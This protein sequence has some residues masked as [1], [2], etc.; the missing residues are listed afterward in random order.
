QELLNTST[1]YV[2]LEPCS[3]HG[4]TPPCVD[5]IIQKKIPHVVIGSVD[6][7][8]LVSGKGIE[9][10][11]SAGIKVEYGVLEKECR[12]LNKRFYTFH[13]KK[14]PYIIL[15]WAQTKDGFIDKLRSANEVGQQLRISSEASARL[16]HEWRSQEQA[17]MVGTNTALL[18]NP[19]L[20]VR[21]V[22]GK[23]PVRIVI[24]KEL[25]IPK[26]YH[27]LDGASPT[28]I[29]TNLKK[30]NSTNIEYI[31]VKGTKDYACDEK[32]RQASEGRGT[33]ENSF[34]NSILPELYQ[35][36][37]QSVLVEGGTKLINSFIQQNLWDEARV[38]VNEN[39]IQTGV[40]APE[41]GG[42]SSVSEMVIG[43]DTI[44]FYSN[45]SA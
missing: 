28:L 24:D 6:S 17:I 23:N 19:Q 10:L 38:I 7:N 8:P 44:L 14:R 39:T 15:K 27:L 30:E 43:E 12:E 41:L 31:T 1:L 42:L 40:K 36:N 18:D 45:K 2:S 9:K 22:K 3:H 33:D 16:I 5:L 29:F 11:K 25:K 21:L 35:R 32:L 37:I 34:I 26:H 4:K 13:E 20:N